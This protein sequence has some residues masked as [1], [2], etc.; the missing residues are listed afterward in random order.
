[1]YIC[2]K[3]NIDINMPKQKPIIFLAFANEYSQGKYLRHLSTESKQIQEVL[4]SAKNLCETINL[5][6][7]T[8]REIFNK[9]QEYRD[10]IAIFHF[11]GHASVNELLL[12]SLE[13]KSKPAYAIGFAQL[14]S[15][16]SGLVLVFL[17]GCST[18]QQVEELLKANITAVIAT[19]E[20]IDDRVACM[21]AT[22]FYRGLANG[23]T[24]NNA[25]NEAVAETRT[26][27]GNNF[28]DVYREE[29]EVIE[30]WPWEIRYKDDLEAIKRWNLP[31]A[32]GDPLFGLPKILSGVLPNQPF[33]NLHRFTK[34]HTRIF[35]GRNYQISRL[36][37]QIVNTGNDSIVLLYGQSGVGKSSLL[38]AGLIPR[39]E[40]QH[41][42]HCLRR[43]RE[44]GLLDT[45]KDAIGAKSDIEI[46]EAWLALETYHASPV[47]VIIDQVEEV[48]TQS[49]NNELKEL[50]DFSNSLK[51][52]FA[53]FNNRPQGKLV[54][55][56]RKEW[57]P[58]IEQLLQYNLLSYS[59]IF[60]ECLDR[61]GI[62]EAIEGLTYDDQ[63]Q[64]KYG[65]SIKDEELPKAIADD[66]LAD[67][68]SAIAPTL[69]I[70]LTKMWE[71]AKQR[72]YNQPCFDRELYYELK[73]QGI[74]LK[75]LLTQ[76][77]ET[78][79][80]WNPK[81]IDSGFV[82]DFLAFHTSRLST[83]E[84]HFI[85][86]LKQRYNHQSHIL[87]SLIEKCKNLYLLVDSSQDRIESLEKVTTRL[88]H[89]TLAPL[90]REKFELSDRPGQRARRILENQGLDW[91]NGKQGNV[92]NESDL[93]LVEEG[94]FGMRAW[95]PDEER[96][97]QASRQERAKK[98]RQRIITK[99]LIIVSITFIILFA[100][101][102]LWQ[103][104]LAQ[105][106]LL[107]FY[108]EQGRQE[109]LNGNPSRALVYLNEAYHGGKDSFSLRFLI[110]R[111]MELYCP[112]DHLLSGHDDR[113]N[114]A[115]FSSDG[116]YVAT[117][118]S[119]YTAK[120]WDV[121]SGKSL[122]ALPKQEDIVRLVR[123]SPESKHLLTASDD[124]KAKIWSVIDGRLLNTL[125]GHTEKLFSVSYSPDGSKILTASKDKTAKI[126][127][128]E[129]GK[130]L[131]TLT[132]HTE[133]VTSAVF[134]YN[135]SYVVTGSSDKTAI[136]W[137]TKNGE[138][139]S[140]LKEHTQDISL[141]AVSPDSQQIVTASYDKTAIIW[142]A[143]NGNRLFTL[144]GHTDIVNFVC[145]S[146]DGSC[147]VTTSYDKTAKVWDTKN[148][149]LIVSLIGHRAYL[150][151]A[152]FSPDGQSIVT[153]SWDT[154]AKVWDSK[155][156]KLTYSLDGHTSDVNSAMFSPDGQYI[157]TAS[158]DKTARIWQKPFTPQP[159]NLNI[160]TQL[161]ANLSPDCQSIANQDSSGVTKILS[162]D[163][164]KQPISLGVKAIEAI[165]ATFSPDGKN[166]IT[167]LNDNTALV[168]DVK[169]GQQLISLKGH[170]DIIFSAVF[171]SN[172]K[173]VA[174]ISNDKTVRVWNIA[175]G[176]TL[177]CLPHT[178]KI[179]TVNFSS[180]D[181]YIVTASDDR[182]AKIWEVT[183]GKL[184]VF[185]S[186]SE[187]VTNALFDK[188]GQRIISITDDA[189]VTIWDIKN[190]KQLLSSKDNE[191]YLA[192][193][194]DQHKIM[195]KDISNNV[196]LWD[197]YDPSKEVLLE[198]EQDPVTLG[199]F[200]H[201]SQSVITVIKDR[202]LKV[203]D[204]N[205]GKLLALENTQ[206]LKV[207]KVF[208]SPRDEQIIIVSHNLSSET[209]I[210]VWNI[211]L[212]SEPK[213]ITKVLEKIPFQLH[214]GR[215]IQKL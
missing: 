25:Y 126:W 69:Q 180:N 203:W 190:Q 60:I 103:K 128:A 154:T 118:S 97:V 98:Q 9:F 3:E 55:C 153:A 10:Q 204:A 68:G 43:N 116:R 77:L 99:S 114:F 48:Y 156:G 144:A 14:L 85:T 64:T 93:A 80:N 38:E 119:D 124:G 95:L 207:E 140:I 89:D 136:I 179:N 197:I 63:L 161:F 121:K 72:N 164:S 185:L 52:L 57:L 173:L 84:Q 133:A 67:Q 168:W 74:L 44:K 71:V 194:S 138:S 66:M 122:I 76:Q 208:F 132:G 73:R 109:L 182:T 189:K 102:A 65:L 35:F 41:K 104:N 123:F 195:L 28:R 5:T 23:A 145:Y 160:A 90:V 141:V 147:L 6:N 36:Y 15:R 105:N 96:L 86:E 157:V 47:T 150:N 177:A 39:L 26:E 82:F 209:S 61:N 188:Y 79:R 183:T 50:Q 134:S 100:T 34:E 70:L 130:L 131:L 117:A 22:R 206:G 8:S 163:N 172:S 45:L 17:N 62:I 181:K 29:V 16:Q 108:Q 42:V 196:K 165:D 112:Q 210:R 83:A 7:V 129:S 120:I 192:I 162:I 155:T 137:D 18:Q 176:S 191:Q 171:S 202:I 2:D 166:I 214:N 135:N 107:D 139:L 46:K 30:R 106:I 198:T 199:E 151:S 146:P 19:S 40:T 4:D 178:E 143:K 159:H 158:E 193:S 58:E 32:C 75:D 113:I 169:T 167:I 27:K 51:M 101:I 94:R 33:R 148:G 170:K 186:H 115:I 127:D 175:N 125:E 200:S 215:L 174:T 211:N 11:G 205:T 212:E 187:N 53:Q 37:K 59:S 12:E 184:L 111:A 78:L 92:L 81:L 91:Q 24:I 88:V 54:L 110:A 56:F 21:F 142:D 201:N 1:M 87:E 13:G 20:A 149:K 31:E 49:L 152:I 213:T